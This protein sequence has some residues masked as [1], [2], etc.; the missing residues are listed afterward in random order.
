[1]QTLKTQYRRF[2]ISSGECDTCYTPL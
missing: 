2:V 1:M